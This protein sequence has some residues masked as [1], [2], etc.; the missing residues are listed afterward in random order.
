MLAGHAQI[1]PDQVALR[2]MNHP[3]GLGLHNLPIGRL[4]E[5]KRH[6]AKGGDMQRRENS[7]H[8]GIVASH[9]QNAIWRDLAGKAS[10]RLVVAF[11]SKEIGMVEFDVGDDGDIG[12]EGPEGTVVFVCFDDDVLAVRIDGKITGED[13]ASI[14]DR[15]DTAMVHRVSMA[16]ATA[17]MMAMLPQ[18][19]FGPLGAVLDLVALGAL[20]ASLLRSDP[21][22]LRLGEGPARDGGRSR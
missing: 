1:E 2:R 19:L 7:G 14:M 8:A 17:G 16:L 15:L 13:L 12:I 9:D 3:S 4:I 21:L 10:E 22:L 5:S 20:L 6:N 18:A 11:L